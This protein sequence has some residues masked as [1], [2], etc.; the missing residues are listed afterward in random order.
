MEKNADKKLVQDESKKTPAARELSF[1]EIDKISGAG[2]PDRGI[3][4]PKG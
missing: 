2:T 3:I 4:I 1:D